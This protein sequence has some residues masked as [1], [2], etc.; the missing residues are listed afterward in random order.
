MPKLIKLQHLTSFLACLNLRLTLK[1]SEKLKM[2]E[3]TLVSWH[4]FFIG[5]RGQKIVGHGTIEQFAD[6]FILK[7]DVKSK[8][9]N[10]A[11]NITSKGLLSVF[12]TVTGL[13]EPN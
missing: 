13:Y 11:Y 9:V 1:D 5:L 2:C 4:T 8:L 7:S 12:S 6:F 3:I 10:V